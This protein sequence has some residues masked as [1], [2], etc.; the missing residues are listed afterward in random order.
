MNWTQSSSESVFQ[1]GYDGSAKKYLPHGQPDVHVFGS[2]IPAAIQSI[3][4]NTIEN[5][6][7][8]FRER[9]NKDDEKVEEDS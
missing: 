3:A 6:S 1:P 7:A 9:K 5:W 4:E 8:I 2:S